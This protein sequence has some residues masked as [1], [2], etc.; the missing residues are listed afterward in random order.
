VG[1]CR[2][3]RDL[4]VASHAG[5]VRNGASA[6]EK[7]DRLPWIRYPTLWI[8]GIRSKIITLKTLRFFAA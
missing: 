2:F 8:Q 7:P 3:L 5:K 1:I 4:A 6:D